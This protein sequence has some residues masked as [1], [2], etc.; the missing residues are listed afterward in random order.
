MTDAIGT[1]LIGLGGVAL[2]IVGTALLESVTRTAARRDAAKER[3]AALL[4]EVQE[5]L[6]EF[7][8]EWTDLIG[9][10]AQGKASL[11]TLEV[12][13]KPSLAMSRYRLLTRRVTDDTLRKDLESVS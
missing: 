5:A 3:Q 1:G 8:R 4:R 9:Y 10:I 7:N 2:G 13:S 6:D 12:S 11:A